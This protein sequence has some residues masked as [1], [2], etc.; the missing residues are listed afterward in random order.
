MP[1]GCRTEATRVLCFFLCIIA[2]RWE[3][4]EAQKGNTRKKEGQLV[5]VE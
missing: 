5:D 1:K 3:L 2:N 4:R